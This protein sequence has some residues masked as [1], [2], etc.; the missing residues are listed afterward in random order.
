MMFVGSDVTVAKQLWF[1]GL[2]FW[3]ECKK[4]SLDISVMT[5]PKDSAVIFPLAG[6]KVLDNKQE[7]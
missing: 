6:M 7:L 5:L 1:W 3:G 4:N 2:G